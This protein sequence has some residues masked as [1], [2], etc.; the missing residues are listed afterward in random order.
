MRKEYI[1]KHG[2]DQNDFSN[3]KELQDFTNKQIYTKGFAFNTSANSVNRFPILLGGKC[4]KLYGF[5]IYFDYE[6][7]LETDLIGLV[8]NSEQVVNDVLWLNYN[9]QNNGN[10]CNKDQFF[11]LPR[12]LSGS[13][14]LDLQIKSNI[15]HKVFITFYLSDI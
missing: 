3:Q 15:A 10:V 6:S 13:D 5:N 1:I 4:R 9:P 2:I 7:Q 11:A 14:A 12:K 8:L